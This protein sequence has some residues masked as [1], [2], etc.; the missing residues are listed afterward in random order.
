MDLRD[1]IFYHIYPLG[2]L[3]A[4]RGPRKDSWEERTAPLRGL[5]AWIPA[6]ERIGADTLL[7]GPLFESEYH[8]YDTLD[9]HRV[10]RRLGAQGDLRA[11]AELLDARGI[12]LVLDGVFNHL[13]RNHSIVRDVA[14]RGPASPYAAWIAGYDSG[15]P[16]RGGLPFSYEGWAGHYDLV[17]L[18]TANPEVRDYLIDAALRWIGDYGIAGLRLDAADCLDTEFLRQLGSRCRGAKPGFFLIGEAVHGDHYRRLL[19]EGGLDSVTDY[20]AYKGLWSSCN[21]GNF[22]EISWTLDRLFGPSGLCAG[23]PLYSFADNHD[24]DRVA[25]SLTDAACLYP[26]Y[27]LLFAMPGVPSVYYGSEFGMPGRRTRE[28]DLP[29]RPRLD[30]GTLEARAPHPDLAR[31]VSRFAAARRATYAVRRGDYRLLSVQSRG[32]AF[33]R[34]AGDSH[35][36]IAVNG[37]P[38]P[39]SFSLDGGVLPRGILEDLLEEGYGIESGPSWDGRLIVPPYWLRWLVLRR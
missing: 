39:L 22:F 25:S 20:E 30:A 8:G 2:A 23:R 29:L 18:D 12:G 34:T 24:V 28:D 11:V 33:L 27:G 31:A 38:E 37:G 9:H 26:L 10:D 1:R 35:A 4:L 36:L 5:E 15:G 6:M 14:E 3:G 7:L 19:T 17:K 16:G 32:I 13:G 21:D